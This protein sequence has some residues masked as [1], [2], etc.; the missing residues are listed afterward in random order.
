M[1]PDRETCTDIFWKPGASTA[2]GKQ[3]R[4]CHGKPGEGLGVKQRAVGAELSLS[5]SSREWA[6]SSA[7]PGL[8]GSLWCCSAHPGRYY[9][10]QCLLGSSYQ[11]GG[12]HSL[13]PFHIKSYP[14]TPRINKTAAEMSIVCQ[15]NRTCW[16][17]TTPG[18]RGL[19]SQ[20]IGIHF[21]VFFS[22]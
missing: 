12:S 9:L 22:F 19:H 5:C 2:G 13:V 6:L 11:A 20:G 21:P 8:C 16:S 10:S 17:Q 14:G 1:V 15:M 4:Q 7:A 3:V 18:C